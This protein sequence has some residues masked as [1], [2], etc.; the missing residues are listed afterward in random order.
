MAQSDLVIQFEGKDVN[1]VAMLKSIS[2]GLS[3]LEKKSVETTKK[4]SDNIRNM[5][6]AVSNTTQKLTGA[7]RSQVGM[8]MGMAGIGGL[9]AAIVKGIKSAEDFEHRMTRLSVM[10]NDD[11]GGSIEGVSEALKKLS[12]TSLFT[13]LE[14]ANGFQKISRS[15]VKGTNELKGAM[16]VLDASQKLATATN[17]DLGATVEGVSRIMAAFG[18]SADKVTDTTDRLF[19]ASRKGKMDFNQLSGAMAFLGTTASQAGISFDD[20]LGAAVGMQRAG[21]P[22]RNVT[23]ALN[24]AIQGILK[25]SKTMAMNFQDLGTKY[26]DLQELVRAEGLGGFFGALK[27]MTGGSLENLQKLIPNF[28][29]LKGLSKMTGQGLD[30]MNKAIL[31]FGTNAGVVD[32][33]FKVVYAG[34]DFERFAKKVNGFLRDVGEK[35][36]PKV[37]SS[38]N[39]F[40]AWMDENKETIITL[41]T[42]YGETLMEFLKWIVRN[43]ETIAKTFLVIWAVEKIAA[44]AAAVTDLATSF[45]ALKVAVLAM[46]SSATLGAL[47]A[48]LAKIGAATIATGT[49][50]V[51]AAGYGAYKMIGAIKGQGET[52]NSMKLQ[53]HPYD[54]LGVSSPI[55]SMVDE[56][57][58]AGEMGPP[59][60]PVKKIKTA[61][62]DAKWRKEREDALKALHDFEVSRMNEREKLVEK[63]HAEQ[64]KWEKQKGVTEEER[65]KQLQF[66]QESHNEDMNKFD[67]EQ[68]KKRKEAE[69]KLDDE[70]LKAGE[71]Y[72]AMRM[73]WQDKEDKKKLEGEKYLEE[74]ET[75]FLTEK[76]KKQKIYL[77]D[78]KRIMSMSFIGGEGDRQTALDL[79]RKQE[80]KETG[81][82]WQE[83]AKGF[84]HKVGAKLLDYALRF[85]DFLTTPLSAISDVFGSMMGGLS[86]AAGA[87]FG[88]ITDIFNS[89]LGGANTI[90]VKDMTQK[91]VEFFRQLAAQL[92]AALQWFAKEGA[93]QIIN[94][95]VE[96]LP[97]VINAIVDAIPIILD[98]IINNLD[99]IIIPFVDGILTLIPK[100]IEKIPLL[101]TEIAKM[102]PQIIV[103]IVKALPSIITSIGEGIVDSVGG[104]FTGLA[105]GIMDVFTDK[106]KA[107]KAQEA[108]QAAIKEALSQGKSVSE[109][110]SLGQNAYDQSMGRLYEGGEDL[111]RLQYNKIHRETLAGN[112]LTAKEAENLLKAQMAAD[113]GPKKTWPERKKAMEEAGKQ[114]LA[115]LAVTK[116]TAVADEIIN[117]QTQG[118]EDVDLT[119]SHGGYDSE[120]NPTSGEGVRRP[121]A[122]DAYLGAP[123]KKPTATPMPIRDS[124]VEAQIAYDK[125]LKDALAAIDGKWVTE[126]FFLRQAG[127]KEKD[128]KTAKADFI[129]Q[130][131]D[132]AHTAARAAYEET[133]ARVEAENRLNPAYEWAG[134]MHAGGYIETAGNLARAIRA[135]A[136]VMLPRGLSPDEVPIIAQ[137]GE[138]VMNR[139][140]V[141][142][143]GGKSG[144]DRMNRTGGGA[145]GVVNNVYVEHMMSNDTAQ[146][147]D[148]MISNNLKSGS[149]KL[150]EK[151]NTGRAV[152]YKTRRAS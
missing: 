13:A 130:A 139:N 111:A 89:I 84:A 71:D 82:F 129:K 149:G 142:N 121:E 9:T 110:E 143:Q 36:L 62:E 74:L 58:A 132:A 55:A 106:S 150:Y 152:G 54:S 38:M 140:W 60:P 17:S 102:I 97:E 1:V 90:D 93:P 48:F 15:G 118:R 29:A 72:H 108:K 98:S 50:A 127:A 104:F 128:I 23:L 83:V 68:Y 42:T 21:V 148:G 103:M 43:A 69:Q 49:A 3:T 145:G 33:A 14:L 114:Y 11:F 2:D 115:E 88:K 47:T 57:A 124:K 28:R 70:V 96:S 53:A 32:K 112:G 113:P 20:L 125:A 100:L 135:H 123:G 80:E 101:I 81:T 91:A 73:E 31:E 85:A 35:L 144:I 67:D 24:A 95:F 19:L 4:F 6:N 141:Q 44:V 119:T 45:T 94:A 131:T 8:L 7:L 22:A 10:L 41:L 78:V 52:I 87:G 77:E 79:R 116:A 64:I 39:E 138:A 120:G 107:E 61:E 26:K 34:S 109:A 105:E 99:D 151:F 27:K 59:A 30:E 40:S 126:E 137:A 51:A 133:L 65:D 63:F 37:V 75:S 136:G 25:P 146:V 122:A 18:I 16:E 117:S 46:G 5:S 92:P 76:Q 66:L 147:I 86:G 134:H 56:S 12:K